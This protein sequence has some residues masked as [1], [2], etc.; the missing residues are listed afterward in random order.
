MTLADVL[1]KAGG[2]TDD[3][4]AV[5]AELARVRTNDASG[6][7]ADTLRVPLSRDLAACAEAART[8]LQPHDA[9]F[10]RRDPTFREQAFV[11]LDGEVRFPGTY[12]LLR[13][14]ERVADLV[15]R[16]GGLTELAYPQGARFVRGS[17]AQLAMDLPRALRSPRSDANL[18][19]AR[20]D[21]LH[22]PR[23]TPTVTVEGAVLNPVTALHQP[24]AGIGWY[25]T[26]ASGFRQDANR[27]GVVVVS[28][29]GRV[30]RGGA[31][32][33]GS[34]VI[35]PARIE[36][37]PADHLKDFATLMSILASAAT[38]VYLVGQSAK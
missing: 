9:V 14:D 11:T 4:Y 28:P 1:L 18:V 2:F 26:Q 22:V 24:G 25:V 8:R 6:R 3:A 37:E 5:V 21:T 19:L 23:F 13:E 30:R 7:I 33:P 12:A 27:R 10:I 34:R 20:G 32:E 31:P 29:S 35:V 38:T 16:A 36:D 15:K 17:R